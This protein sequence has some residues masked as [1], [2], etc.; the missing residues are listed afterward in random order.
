MRRRTGDN[1][2]RTDFAHSP[3]NGEEIAVPFIDEQSTAFRKQLEIKPSQLLQRRILTR[4]LDFAL[5]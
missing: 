3:K 1:F 2:E 5:R 4:A